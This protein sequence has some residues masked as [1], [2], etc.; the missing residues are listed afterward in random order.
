[1]LAAT[2]DKLLDLGINCNVAMFEFALK[3]SYV[4]RNLIS[5]MFLFIKEKV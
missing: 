3:C 5:D 1:M 4:I 2:V